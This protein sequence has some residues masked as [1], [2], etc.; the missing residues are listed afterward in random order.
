MH[1]KVQAACAHCFRVFG[2]HSQ[3]LRGPGFGVDNRKR[4]Q[5]DDGWR[6]SLC[7]RAAVA[8]ALVGGCASATRGRRGWDPI[9]TPNRF[10]FAIN[11]TVD[12]IAVRPLA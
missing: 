10:V 3:G 9:E 1:F 7:L 12:M 11:R 2:R 8:A 5:V 4:I 6:P